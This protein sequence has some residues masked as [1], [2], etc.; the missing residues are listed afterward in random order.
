MSYSYRSS[1]SRSSSS[2]SQSS[3]SFSRQY[4]Q[5]SS[6]LVNSTRIVRSTPSYSI[7]SYSTRS[8]VT[9]V[10]GTYTRRYYTTGSA[11]VQSE[12]WYHQL[13]HTYTTSRSLPTTSTVMLGEALM[14]TNQECQQRVSSQSIEQEYGKLTHHSLLRC[15]ASG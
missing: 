1:Y 11:I 12:P 4:G 7:T 15:I 5:S 14:V 3:S 13:S 2:S 9:H 10:G 8:P 6:Q